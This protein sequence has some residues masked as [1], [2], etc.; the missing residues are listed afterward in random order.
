[1]NKKILVIVTALLVLSMTLTPFVLAKP[2]TKE[3]NNEK[4]QS[5]FTTHT[6]NPLPILLAEKSY[7]PSADNPNIIIVSWEE[8]MIAYEIM[9]GEESYSLHEDFEYEGNAVWT[10]IG[11][12]F[13][14]LLGILPLGSKSNHWRIEYTYD[15]S[16]VPDGIE[17]TLEMLMVYNNGETSIRSLRGTGGLQNV[18]I[19]ATAVLGTHEGIVSGWPE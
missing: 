14:T 11:A 1:M 19:M 13:G 15:F 12:P 17:G 4:F 5:F 2:W 6:P 18:Q 9:I 8:S 7:R 10:A 3:K 16:A